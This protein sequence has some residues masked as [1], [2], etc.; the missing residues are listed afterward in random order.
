MKEGAFMQFSIHLISAETKEAYPEYAGH[1]GEIHVEVPPNDD[2]W[3]EMD[4]DNRGVL[5][6]N[7][8][9][10]YLVDF[11]V[12]GF[13]LGFTEPVV[14]TTNHW[15]GKK[16]IGNSKNYPLHTKPCIG[17]ANEVYWQGHIFVNFYNAVMVE[18]PCM[19][20]DDDEEDAVPSEILKQGELI[21][22]IQMSYCSK[23]G[24]IHEGVIERNQVHVK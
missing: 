17:K 1:Y 8:L 3:I 16:L 9:K 6:Q 15:S 20:F 23:A 4:V 2:F 22:S 13:D 12:D 10:Y 19:L 14:G 21:V 11:L 7:A 24:L 18:K 5:Y